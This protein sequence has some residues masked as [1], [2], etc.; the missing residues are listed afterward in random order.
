V[1]LEVSEVLAFLES[2]DQQV[3]REA[4]DLVPILRNANNLKMICPWHGNPSV[5]VKIKLDV[6]VTFSERLLRNLQGS[7]SIRKL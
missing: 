6:S 1:Q 2:S 5:E 4:R 3:E 7:S